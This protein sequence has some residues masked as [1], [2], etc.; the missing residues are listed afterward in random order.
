MF[1]VLLG[2]H[3]IQE[4]W[5]S[6]LSLVSHNP[7]LFSI[8]RTPSH[9]TCKVSLLAL[10]QMLGA[11]VCTPRYTQHCTQLCRLTQVV[12]HWFTIYVSD[13]VARRFC[14]SHVGHVEEVE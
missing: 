9:V 1:A 5:M 10:E 8:E 7:Y 13:Q 4:P 6:E 12:N 14:V 11:S 2:T 3:A